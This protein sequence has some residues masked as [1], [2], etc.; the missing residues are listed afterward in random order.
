M[1]KKKKIKRKVRYTLMLISDCPSDSLKQ[2]SMKMGTFQFLRTT[3]LIVLMICITLSG[4]TIITIR[5]D[6]NMTLRANKEI[7]DLEKENQ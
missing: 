4:Y 3:L 5:G 7:T 2:I 1:D 6:L